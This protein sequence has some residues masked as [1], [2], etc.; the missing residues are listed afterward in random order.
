MGKSDN[1]NSTVLKVARIAAIVV[2]VLW[3]LTFLLFFNNDSGERGQ[4]GDMFGA[5]NALFSGLAFAGLIITLIL[6]KTELGLQR[7]ELEQTRDELKNQR[8][9]FETQNKTLKIQQF[10]SALYS[11][12]QLQQQIVNDL[13]YDSKIEGYSDTTARGTWSVVVKGRELFRFS[14]EQL[15][16]YYISFDGE[17]QTTDGMKGILQH[18][19]I[20]YYSEYT[21]PSYFDHY[22]RHPYRILKFIDSNE[23]LSFEQK[24]KYVGDIRGTLSRYELVWIYYNLL[25]NPKFAEFKRMVE[26][27]SLLKN[28]NETFLALSNENDKIVRL[29]GKKFFASEGF[30]G[31]DYEF[32]VTDKRGDKN[33]FY[34]GT[35]YNKKDLDEGLDLVQHYKKAITMQS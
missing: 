11:M 7:D 8:K 34:I 32:F 20:L 1:D 16:H 25:S 12:L 22:F 14:F 2:V 28:L 23:D 18:L 9:E 19:G 35:F 10:E 24:Y 15:K 31:T 30:S 6:Q 26:D 5:V 17:K 21:T 3:A 27:Y 4:F 33:R 29:K 13:A